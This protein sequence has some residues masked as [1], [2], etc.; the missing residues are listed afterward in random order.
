M[1]QFATGAK[2]GRKKISKSRFFVDEKTVSGKL[3]T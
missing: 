3:N 1:E 2:S